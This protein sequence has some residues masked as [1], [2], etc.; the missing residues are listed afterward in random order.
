MYRTL[1]VLVTFIVGLNAWTYDDYDKR[2]SPLSY[3]RSLQPRVNP[4][5]TPLPPCIPR[6]GPG[7]KG[8]YET[9]SPPSVAKK[10]SLAERDFDL[11]FAGPQPLNDQSLVER[12]FYSVK[13]GNVDSFIKN[14]VQASTTV[15]LVFP[16]AEGD[17]TSTTVQ[18]TF[19]GTNKYEL[20]TGGL[21]GCTV[22]A[23]ISRRGVFMGHFFES[24][25]FDPPTEEQLREEGMDP[26]TYPPIDF[27]GQVTNLIDQSNGNVGGVGPALDVSLF[28]QDTDNTQAYIMTPRAWEGG[29][30]DWQFEGSINAIIAQVKGLL[31]SIDDIPVTDYVRLNMEDEDEK[32]ELFTNA[33]GAAFFQYDPNNRK[34]QAWRL[35]FERNL[36][37]N[38]IAE[39][40]W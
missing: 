2:H 8:A 1:L 7:C 15:Q 37:G 19:D 27:A 33:R 29:E 20:G 12:N 28:N 16:D 36:A 39:D 11:V 35:F 5:D 13:A 18:H 32:A 21:T 22:L 40:S 9:A 3:K 23:V 17:D 4:G 31:P 14:K 38:G 10:R 24:L 30:G 25:A 34:K 26:A 6:C